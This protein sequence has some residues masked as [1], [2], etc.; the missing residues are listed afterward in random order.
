MGV[1]G[2]GRDSMASWLAVAMVRLAHA[3][4]ARDEK[5]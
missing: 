5:S 1:V 3:M 4:E 2:A